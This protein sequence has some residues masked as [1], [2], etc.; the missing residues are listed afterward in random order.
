MA[1]RSNA[2]EVPAQTA[3]EIRALAKSSAGRVRIKS[4]R[5][6]VGVVVSLED[7]KLLERIED[8]RDLQIA[9]ESRARRQAGEPT[10]DFA[11][12]AKKILGV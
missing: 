12:L 2:V 1:R 7:A 6:T 5:R 9:R 10:Y 11:V 3:D 4:G 8:E